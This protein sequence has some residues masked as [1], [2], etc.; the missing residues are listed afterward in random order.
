MALNF[1]QG[2]LLWEIVN[3]VVS[4]AILM[5]VFMVMFKVLPDVELT[6]GDTLTGGIITGVLFFAGSYGISKY[7]AYT[8]TGSAYGAAG[9]LAILLLWMFYSAIIIFFGAELTYAYIT[10]GG[11]RLKPDRFAERTAAAQE[12]PSPEHAGTHS[13]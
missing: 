3:I 4:V 13:A 2:G 12:E 6:W 11:R 10:Q 7:L 8:G 5:L 1:P 9:S